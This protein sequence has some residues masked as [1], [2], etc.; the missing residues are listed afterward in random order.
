M[1]TQ[2]KPLKKI[3]DKLPEY[4]TPKKNIKINPKKLKSIKDKIKK[5]YGKKD[6]KII[7]SKDLFGTLKI[8]MGD[9]WIFFRTSRTEHSVFRIITDAPSESKAKKLLKEAITVSNP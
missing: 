8:W 7:D 3:I 2:K 4:Y 6:C 1:A 5:Y 9:S